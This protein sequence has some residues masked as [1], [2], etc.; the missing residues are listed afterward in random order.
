MKI[1]QS[2]VVPSPHIRI[3]RFTVYEDHSIQFRGIP[4]CLLACLLERRAKTTEPNSRETSN[5]LRSKINLE[6]GLSA[7]S[8]IYSGEST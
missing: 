4:V 8:D 3:F 5:V 1:E 7:A 6:L 2:S